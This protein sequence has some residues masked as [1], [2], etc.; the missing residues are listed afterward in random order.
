LRCISHSNLSVGTNDSS[1]SVALLLQML[2]DQQKFQKMLPINRAKY[3]N[4]RLTPL[5][6]FSLTGGVVHH[7]SL[8]Q[9]MNNVLSAT[10]RIAFQHALF[11]V[12]LAAIG[13]R[14]FSLIIL[15]LSKVFRPSPGLVH[16]RAEPDLKDG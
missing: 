6:L 7:I 12:A 1:I 3:A 9:K 14:N 16:V 5:E 4:P 13:M 15:Q 2:H 8:Q 11:C 10:A